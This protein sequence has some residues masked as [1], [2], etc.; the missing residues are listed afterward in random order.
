MSTLSP[1]K[2]DISKAIDRL[3][4]LRDRKICVSAKS[5]QDELDSYE[6]AKQMAM[7]AHQICADLEIALCEIAVERA[8]KELSRYTREAF[9]DNHLIT[10]AL[11]PADEWADDYATARELEDA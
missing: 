2:S 6:D 1:H 4:A 3:I 9:R 10:D 8:G 7:D 11:F 5:Q